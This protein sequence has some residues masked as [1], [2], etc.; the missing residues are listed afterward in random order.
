MN[1]A[2]AESTSTNMA[3]DL[4]ARML[5]EPELDTESIVTGKHPEQTAIPPFD[6]QTSQ[7]PGVVTDEQTEQSDIYMSG[8]TVKTLSLD[9]LTQNPSKCRNPG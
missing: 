8:A 4:E 2:M 6:P 1:F 9:S 3:E 7:T 5:P